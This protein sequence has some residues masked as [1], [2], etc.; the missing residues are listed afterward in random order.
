MSCNCPVEDYLSQKLFY[1]CGSTDKCLPKNIE[2]DIK[3]E[4]DSTLIEDDED[5]ECNKKNISIKN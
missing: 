4:C 2:C 3:R 5:N 1:R